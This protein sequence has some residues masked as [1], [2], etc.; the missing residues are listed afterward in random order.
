MSI[1][2]NVNVWDDPS[3]SHEGT[4]EPDTSPS[5]ATSDR[6]GAEAGDGGFPGTAL[7]PIGSSAPGGSS[8]AAEELLRGMSRLMEALNGERSR[9]EEAE[10]RGRGAE[11]ENARLRAELNAEREIRR[12]SEDELERLRDEIE[13]RQ[14]RSRAELERIQ[15]R[16]WRRE[17]EEEE[18]HRRDGRDRREHDSAERESGDQ[19]RAG[20]GAQAPVPDPVQQRAERDR[21]GVGGDEAPER[22]ASPAFD[23]PKGEAA[24]VETMGP[25]DQPQELGDHSAPAHPRGAPPPPPPSE[26]AIPGP[27]SRQEAASESDVEVPLPPG[28]RYASEAQP[29]RPRRG[30]WRKGP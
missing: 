11:I 7:S 15:E 9:T 28:W 22:S 20:V 5:E 18:Q 8:R 6:H 2:E 10:Q 13:A 30:W 17:Q 14:R 25:G 12:R 29:D 16:L 26:D 3:G 4:D 21:V 24:G 27:A 19:Y 1:D 23:E